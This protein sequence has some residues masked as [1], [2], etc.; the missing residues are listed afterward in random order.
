M[1]SASKPNTECIGTTVIQSKASS[2]VEDYPGYIS[3]PD[4]ASGATSVLVQVY[5]DPDDLPRD[6]EAN[7]Y[8]GKP[9][10][11]IDEYNDEVEAAGYAT[12]GM[13]LVNFGNYLL[14]T[15]LNIGKAKI[16]P[17]DEDLNI[18]VV[19]NYYK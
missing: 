9:L 7:D 3:V 6:K 13:K 12:P 17:L 15:P 18:Y 14:E 16:I 4:A 5:F 2:A 11:A 8:A 19:L 10:V 1:F